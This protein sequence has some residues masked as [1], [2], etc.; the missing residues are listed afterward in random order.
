MNITHEIND[1]LV[2][3]ICIKFV[4]EDYS[5]DYKKVIADYRKKANIP[6][7]R[8]GMVPLGM[9][10]KMYGEAIMADTISGKIG[11]ALDNFLK[12]KNFKMLGQPLPDHA[13]QKPINFKDDKEFEFFYEVGLQPEINLEIDE[14]IAADYFDIEVAADA[15]D[16]YLMEMRRKFGTSTNPENV[17]EGDVVF[18]KVVEVDENGNPVDGG[19]NKDSSILVDYIKLK[20]VKD[21]FLKANIGSEIVFNPK[22][23]MKKD[24]EIASFL[25][26]GLNGAKDFKNDV[27]FVLDK[28]NHIEP[29]E[30]NEELFSKVYEF[31]QITNEEE[32]RAR[33]SRDIVATYQNEGKNQF[34]NDVVDKLLEITNLTLPDDFLKRWILE[35]NQQEKQ[36]DRITPEQLEYQYEGYKNTLKWQ[37]IEGHLAEKY[38]MRI[39][40]QEIKDRVK[41]LLG[42]QAFGSEDNDSTREIIDQ[43]TESVMKNQEEVKRIADQIMEQKLTN[44]FL[45]NMKVNHKSISYD[46]FVA[47]VSSKV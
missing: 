22:K 9:I 30:L 15:T 39:T 6:G 35:N 13:K 19:V 12:E 1:N 3:S 17:S 29:A 41:E 43:V 18:G 28:I 5:T 47:M 16:N 21:K 42:M 7:F 4:E 40:N 45:S 27:K 32:L 10:T 36:E 25:G 8:K 37:L 20:A 23:A 46:D 38:N 31:D 11:D 14:N 24:I 44:L 26:I 34:M 33:I 2:V